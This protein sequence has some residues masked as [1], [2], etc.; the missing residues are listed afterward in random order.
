MSKRQQEV[1]LARGISCNPSTL[2]CCRVAHTR[3]IRVA[4]LRR[5]LR[6][7]AIASELQHA[8]VHIS[9]NRLPH[10]CQGGVL[11]LPTESLTGIPC[12]RD[13]L[14]LGIYR[15]APLARS[16]PNRLVVRLRADHR[17]VHRDTENDIARRSRPPRDHQNPANGTRMLRESVSTY[18]NE[19]ERKWRNAR[20]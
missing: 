7:H 14:R 18:P 12:R 2:Q 15:R 11:S 13:R 16:F 8:S 17:C 5:N 10:F 20:L 6:K 19:K 3:P 9:R 1:H 4:S